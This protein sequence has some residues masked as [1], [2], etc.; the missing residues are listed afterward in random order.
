MY[1]LVA[2]ALPFDEPTIPALFSKIKTGS[3]SMPFKFSGE[4]KDLIFRMLNPDAVGR[5]T[6]SQIKQH[7]WFNSTCSIS[8]PSP[9]LSIKCEDCIHERVLQQVLSLEDFKQLTTPV[10]QLRTN[11]LKNKLDEVT[12]AYRILVSEEM[13]DLR[14]DGAGLYVERP[15]GN[16]R[17]A[18]HNRRRICTA[19]G[20][21]THTNWEY[22][23][24]LGL[25]PSEFMEI[26]LVTFKNHDFSWKFLGNFSVHLRSNTNATGL[27]LDLMA[28]DSYQVID[29]RIEAGGTLQT[30]DLISAVYAS[31]NSLKQ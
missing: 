20:T 17:A 22:G 5:C 25:R 18:G 4:L 30:L 28:S 23:I 7:P 13:K 11:I 9:E 15:A 1:A 2:G 6:I 24:R 16:L 21:S 3:F 26:V 14:E 8:V 31:L 10:E 27:S 29:F 19:P 12:V